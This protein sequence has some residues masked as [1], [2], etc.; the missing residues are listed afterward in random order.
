MGRPAV[1][2]SHSSDDSAA[3]VAIAKAL[4]QQ[5]VDSWI[6]H[7]QI[8]PGDSILSRIEEGIAGCDVILVLISESFVRSRWCRAE[9]EPLLSKE[10]E[11]GQTIVIPVRLDD[12][13]VPLLLSA[14]KYAD[15]RRGVDGGA[16]EE[17]AEAILGERSAAVV[18]R[19]LPAPEE[20]ES[21]SAGY[22]CSLL[23]MIISKVIHDYPVA[24]ISREK[25]LHGRSIV[26]LYRTVESLIIHYEDLCDEILDLL[27]DADYEHHF[28]GSAGRVPPRRI[29][30]TNRKLLDI[31]NDM[32]DIARSLDGIIG[33][34]S[35]LYRRF[36]DVLELCTEISVAEDF[37]LIRLGAPPVLPDRPA[38]YDE[39]MSWRSAYSLFCDNANAPM[40]PGELGRQTID[41]LEKVLGELNT[42]KVQLR[43]A[44]A[45]ISRE[46]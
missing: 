14:K 29:Q 6:D 20:A 35:P 5:G 15:L 45:A 25:I 32:R 2:I 3:A 42:Y 30:R 24:A 11:S 33:T 13:K 40:F 26:D 36:S 10:I 27:E 46:P 23:S 8:R 39:A 41:D 34:G 16:L 43:S 7:E 17:L 19:L 38:R 21:R 4:R 28:Y 9:Y 12:A 18:Q 37:L 31:A 44:I 22:E 1:F